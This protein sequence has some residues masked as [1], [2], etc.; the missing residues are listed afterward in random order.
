MEA[1]ERKEPGET[2]EKSR[3]SELGQRAPTTGNLAESARQESEEQFR[4]LFIAAAV[5]IAL[6]T[7]QG[8]F[9]QANAAYCRMLGY[10]EEE[11]QSLDFSAVTHPEDLAENL[12]LRDDVL[13]GRRESFFMAKRYLK[14]G[15]GIV[16][17]RHSVS[18]VRGPGGEVVKMIVTAEDITEQKRS[19]ARYRR[20]VDSDVQAVIF[21]TLQGEITDANDAFLRLT[22]FTRADLRAGRINWARMT[23]PE[24]AELDRRAVAEIT[25]RGT[26]TPYEKEWIRRDGSRVPVLLG[27]AVF[28]DKA[29]EGV[30]FAIDLTERVKVE[31]AL[32]ASEKRFKA[33]FTQSAVGVAQLQAATGRIVQVNQRY[34][35]IVGRMPV[36]LEGFTVAAITH[37]DDFERNE[38]IFERLKAG[39][40]R[41]FSR[42][43]R[44]IRKDGT[45]VWALMAISAMWSPGEPPDYFIA[46]IQDITERKRLE[47][48]FRQAQKM[49]A[50]GT[51]AGGIAHDFNN[52]LTSINGYTE[53]AQR[54]LEGNP[55]VRDYL[56]SVRRAGDRAAGL[57]RQILSFSRQETPDRSPIHLQSVVAESIK[58]LRASIPATAEFAT[59]LATDAPAVLADATQINQILLNLGTNAWHAMRDRPGRIGFTLERCAVDAEGAAAHPR[60]RPGIYARVSVSDTGCGMDPATLRRIFEPF[61]TTKPPG[62]GT[63]LG[64]AVV[65]G[66]MESHDGAVTGSSRPGAGT[67]FQLYFPA[68]AGEVAA[69]E[70]APGP[71]PAG[72]GE[73]I[74][75]VD[76]EELLVGLG[77]AALRELG[78]AVESVTRPAAALEWVR[79]DP[80]RFAL[81]LTDQTMPGM[82]GLDLAG[83]LQKIRPDLPVILMT[84]YSGSLAPERLAAAGIRRLLLKPPTLHALA[85][86][87]RAGLDGAGR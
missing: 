14:K 74:L 37:P 82:T 8:R 47:D 17:A 53:L 13:A 52:L 32:R 40:I 78:Y 54:K 62:E 33:L 25:A 55:E 11:L 80:A 6:S 39:S 18:A 48:Q 64:L 36:E 59:S 56:D 7:P 43:K 45:T 85:A 50:M 2:G 60:L 4:S 28:E 44:Y 46:V 61:F 73:R 69:A 71:E 1:E 41:E 67:M 26:C 84:G 9:L 65:H 29:D 83:E 19:E 70:P 72:R 51:L 57:V 15:G 87:V 21:W 35:E 12:Q 31:A 3:L 86:A 16:W 24:Y 76:D 66:I 27:S 58:L 63:G 5:G 10:S 42:E 23:P 68:Y 30:C 81:V 75:L 79:A 20:L 34:C 38:E 77:E 49:E 22:G